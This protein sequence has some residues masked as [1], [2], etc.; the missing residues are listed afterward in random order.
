MRC[1][2]ERCKT[3]YLQ[4][5]CHGGVRFSGRFALQD[6]VC[7]RSSQSA[8]DSHGN[9]NIEESSAEH[10]IRD[11]KRFKATSQI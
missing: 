3:L 4:A 10:E 7:E 8:A 11:I 2:N 5:I 9:E 6:D 1:S